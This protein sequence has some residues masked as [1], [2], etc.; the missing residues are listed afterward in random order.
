MIRSRTDRVA[1]VG[2][3]ADLLTTQS[4]YA[5]IAA[6][7]LNAAFEP[8]PGPAPEPGLTRS[9]AAIQSLLGAA[10]VVSKLMWSAGGAT[11]R[12]RARLLREGLGVSEGQFPRLRDRAVRDSLEHV[13]ER[14]DG[15][16]A[17]GFPPLEPQ[18]LGAGDAAAILHGGPLYLRRID[19][20][21]GVVEVLGATVPSTRSTSTS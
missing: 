15:Y 20:S 11:A 3:A 7:N 6:E 18:V 2:R 10:A 13:D 16:L 21:G 17:G 9:F 12:Q 8:R 5:A 19:P 1:R 14:I 4:Q